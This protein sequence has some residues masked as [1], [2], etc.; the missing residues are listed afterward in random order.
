MN[1]LYNSRNDNNGPLVSAIIP[2]Y[3]TCDYLSQCLESI[4]SQTYKNIEIIIVDDGSTDESGAICDKFAQDNSRAF[5]LHTENN[6][7]A[8]ARN[9]GIDN[10]EGSF[11]FFLDSDDW[12]EAGTVGT[13]LRNAVKYEADIV[14]ARRCSEYVDLTVY[15]KPNETDAQSFQGEDI[16]S[17]FADGLFSDTIW[18]KLYHRKC[19]DS[20]RF[21]EG[22]NHEDLAVTWRLLKNLTNNEGKVAAIPDILF[23][24]RMRKS[25]IS[26]TRS[27][28]NIADQWEASIDKY[29]GLSEYREKLVL[30]CISVI[31][32][33]WIHY[34]NFTREDR[35]FADSVAAEMQRFSKRHFHQ[36]MRG[37]Y[38][39]QI[40]LRCV[41]S[42]SSAPI[43]LRACHVAGKAWQTLRNKRYKMFE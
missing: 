13:L 36:I 4:S 26:N 7:L 39:I 18:N 37:S 5:V 33:M 30:G 1:E 6:G 32:S 3:N 23:H 11:L 21:P 12:V 31:G 34:C 41:A 38:P 28:N 43:V 29:D 10:A 2:V 25:S 15:P 40:K 27:V 24:Q 35:V 14:C 9:E 17:A 16:L 42:Q 8:A 22:H 19:F 20:I